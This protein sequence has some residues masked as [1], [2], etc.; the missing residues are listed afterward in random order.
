[1]HEARNLH[2]DILLSRIPD[3]RKVRWFVP[4]KPDP[5]E[6]A[7]DVFP[8]DSFLLQLKTCVILKDALFTNNPQW[9]ARRTSYGEVRALITHRCHENFVQ[10][11]R[12][13]ES[14]DTDL[15]L[16]MPRAHPRDALLSDPFSIQVV[17]FT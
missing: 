5:I 8:V 16:P 4:K 7:I 1:M 11:V 6:T 2:E 3:V 17:I 15:H 14:T 10:S 9:I 13:D 12:D